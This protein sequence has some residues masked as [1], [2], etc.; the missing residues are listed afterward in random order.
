MA[1][2]IQWE[3]RLE[4]IGGSAWR[5]PKDEDLEALLDAWGEEGWEVINVFTAPGTNR[6]TVVAKRPLARSTRRHRS[7]PDY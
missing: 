6:I 2:A 1:Q 4:T 5:A 3:Y 7:M